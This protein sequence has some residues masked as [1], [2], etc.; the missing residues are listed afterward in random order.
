VL[1]AYA[2]VFYPRETLFIQNTGTASAPAGFYGRIDE[3]DIEPP[4]FSDPTAPDVEVIINGKFQTDTGDVTGQA[5]YQLVIDNAESTAGFSDTSQINGCSFGSGSCTTF[6]DN[7]PPPTNAAEIA[8]V[9][10]Q[11][12]AQEEPFDPDNEEDKEQAEEAARAPIAPPVVL[13]DSRPLNP[14]VDVTDPVSGTG[15]PALIGASV[16]E[17][18]QGD[19]Q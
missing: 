18:A 14:D 6:V 1:S 16:R 15:N 5:A 4:G 2:L 12:Q 9:L 19:Q 8:A 17:S 13:I 11:D 7:T 3:S 10:T